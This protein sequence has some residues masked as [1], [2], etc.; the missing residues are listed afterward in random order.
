MRFGLRTTLFESNTLVT[1]DTLISRQFV[2]GRR[3]LVVV[4][5]NSTFPTGDAFSPPEFRQGP[6]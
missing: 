2:D 3:E 4:P 1:E 5:A 6:D